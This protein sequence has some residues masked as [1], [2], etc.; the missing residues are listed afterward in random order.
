MASSKEPDFRPAMD[1]FYFWLGAVP[2]L[3]VLLAL[4]V[5]VSWTGEDPAIAVPPV[6]VLLAVL[7]LLLLSGL[8]LGTRYSVRE[9]GLFVQFAFLSSVTIPYADITSVDIVNSVQASAALSR[10]RIR[11]RWNDP[12]V[13]W[14]RRREISPRDEAGL[15][16]LLRQRVT[17]QAWHIEAGGTSS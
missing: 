8:V 11:I 14:E 9:A 17:P 10:R 13:P 3:A 4:I 12:S 15:L 2:L 1:A 16:A 6:L 7:V 5:N